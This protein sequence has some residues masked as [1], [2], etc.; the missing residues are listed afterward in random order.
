MEYSG[1]KIGSHGI[2]LRQVKLEICKKVG[3]GAGAD[4]TTE[5]GAAG[6]IGSIC[7]MATAAATG[8]GATVL[9]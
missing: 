5:R 7:R 6:G 3:V 8:G 9:V 4:A 1:R 2:K